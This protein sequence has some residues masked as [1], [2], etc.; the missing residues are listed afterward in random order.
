MPPLDMSMRNAIR[1]APFAAAGG[2]LQ[3]PGTV[4]GSG[5]VEGDA[6]AG[7]LDVDRDLVL[8][9]GVDAVGGHEALSVVATV[10]PPPHLGLHLA[11]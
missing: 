5:E 4:V 10:G 3:M 6:A 11:T 2:M 1:T 8:L 9:R 7:N